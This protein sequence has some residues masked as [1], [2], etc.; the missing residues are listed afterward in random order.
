MKS[1]LLQWALYEVLSAT[2]GIICSLLLQ[3]AL[4]AAFCY[5]AHYLKRYLQ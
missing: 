2:A 3:R 5:N 4:Y 1:Y